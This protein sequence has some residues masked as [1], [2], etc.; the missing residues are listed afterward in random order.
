M[1][2]KKGKHERSR[3]VMLPHTLLP[4]PAFMVGYQVHSVP[5]EASIANYLILTGHVRP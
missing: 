3:E 2:D 5:S 1:K 4:I